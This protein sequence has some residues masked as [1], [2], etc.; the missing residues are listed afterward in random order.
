MEEA[1]KN[2]KENVCRIGLDI[3]S[4][5]V[6]VVVLDTAENIIYSCYQRHFAD[7]YGTIE[8][9]LHQIIK[10][11]GNCCVRMAV[12]GS[13]GLS[14]SEK[15]GLPF[16]QEV[17]A[18]SVAVR[19][20]H[21]ETTAVLELGGEDAKLTFF[22]PGID[23][24]MNGICAGGTGAFID[25]MAQLLKTDAAGL[26]RLAQESN[27]I[28]PIAARCGVFAKTD[29]Q[30]LLNDGARREDIA[31]S[32]FQAV[33]N[34][35]IGGLSCGRKIGGRV[36]LIGGPL[37]FLPQ[38]R[39]RF[40]ETLNLPA[41]G[42]VLPGNAP[43]FVALGA[44]LSANTAGET[45]CKAAPLQALLDTIRHWDAREIG[46][47]T[48]LPPLFEN[49]AAYEEFTVRHQTH[50]I[51][52]NELST[53]GGNC[54]LGLDVGSTTCKSVLLDDDAKLLFSCYANND[55]RPLDTAARLLK[56]LFD[57][58]P[59]GVTIARAAVTGYGENLVKAAF[60]CDM[61]EVETV[62]HVTAA[63]YFL[64]GV[65]TVLDIGGQ[66]MKYL[67]VVGGII[68]NMVLNE[69]CSSGCGSFLQT[70][71]A[72]VGLA[73]PAF[74]QAAL[75][76]EAPVDLGSRCTVFMTSR[77]RQAQ[78]EGIP[79]GDIA[80][81]L[82][83]AV[84]KN[85]LYKVVKLKDPHELGEKI[86][87]Q[88]GTFKNDAV[89][90]CFELITGRQAVRPDIPELMGAL[91]AAL[92]ARNSWREGMGS[93]L[94]GPR[95]LAAF[96]YSTSVAHCGRC[97]NNCLLT[98]A[99]FSGDGGSQR[100]LITGNRCEKGSGAEKGQ[101]AVNLYDYKYQ[102]LFSYRP[103]AESKAPRGTIG[104]PRVL[105]MYENYPF[106]HTF[107]TVLGFRVVLS[108][109]SSR[110]IYA[111]GLDTISSDTACY[112]AKLANG[113]V[114]YLINQGIRHIFLPCLPKERAEFQ[115]ADNH[116]NCPIVGCYAEVLKAN[117]DLLKER[118]VKFYNP[119]LPYHHR[120]RLTERLCE[121]FQGFHLSLE[122]VKQAVDAA[123]AEDLRFKDDIRQKGAECLQALRRS[124]KGGIVLSGR[125]YHLDPEVHHGIPDLIASMGLA[126]LTEDA[127]AHLGSVARPLRVLDQWMYHT[128][129]YEA[130][131][132]VA[133]EPSLELVQLNSFGCGPDSIA[134]EQAQE[135]LMKYH[136]LY[137]LIKI[138][139]IANLGSVQTRRHLK[140]LGM[141]SLRSI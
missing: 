124:G 3:G 31:A 6:K 117:I 133:K 105:N 27:M 138:D 1:G 18:G 92:L 44:A 41:Q 51:G 104:I 113:H 52:T 100:T 30:A 56:T 102:R 123:W 24:R 137:T 101:S 126:V 86:I 13:G 55:G 38:L 47:S 134:A 35:T 120:R 84:V 73:V 11:L 42:L 9:I 72:S 14:F 77:V 107:F 114:V 67:N 49:S 20:F 98:V 91:G 57:S 79:L 4:T 64:P 34:Q 59:A 88:G 65:D 69:A 5:T 108:P 46:V 23:H 85:A 25:H 61:G 2:Q 50:K 115:E 43:V 139:E 128:R 76:A 129:L 62:A 132:F 83:Y 74:A 60:C 122:E 116:Y 15:L 8:Q 48:R 118:D 112:P 95:E 10:T 19:R 36:C 29:I 21:P 37:H 127:V 71:A 58:L 16:V 89:L 80:G 97:Q 26:N 141:N 12:T 28:Y 111:L 135:I 136:K 130:A 40:Q 106:W 81:G 93:S 109:P 53:Y 125:P 7:L 39:R 17:V 131:D 33:V 54:F 99:H 96:S 63:E 68:D 32:I 66:D 110:D 45:P 103:L 70:F 90:R 82:C 78:K 94:I 75:T 140:P 121:E 87:V 22:D 119:F